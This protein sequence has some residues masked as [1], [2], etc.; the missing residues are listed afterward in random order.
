MMID[1][2]AYV[3]HGR[4][5]AIAKRG[6]CVTLKATRGIFD[7]TLIRLHSSPFS[8]SSLF[9]PDAKV[10]KVA[11]IVPPDANSEIDLEEAERF[12][13]QI[14]SLA[15]LSFFSPA[16]C[17]YFSSRPCDLRIKVLSGINCH[18]MANGDYSGTL[19]GED[20]NGLNRACRITCHYRSVNLMSS[21]MNGAR[22]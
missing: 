1:R 5:A 13:H 3:T 19:P 8:P 9:C 18:L 21:R 12:F 6:N 11:E 4:S 2:F 22:V 17:R 20:R 16:A 10:G 14:G 15:F 7:S